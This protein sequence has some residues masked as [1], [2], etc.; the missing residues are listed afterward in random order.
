MK[1]DIVCDREVDERTAP[2]TDYGDRTYYFCSEK[3]ETAFVGNPL[4]FVDK[5]HSAS[6]TEGSPKI[7]ASG[8]EVQ[9]HS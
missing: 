1:K 3:C 6:S 2:R 8:Q 4:R 7:T 5:S 9:S